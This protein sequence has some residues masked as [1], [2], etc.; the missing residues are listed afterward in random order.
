MVLAESNTKE[1]AAATNNKGNNNDNNK[2]LIF[3]LATEDC[4]NDKVGGG[5][6][7]SC[8][9]SQLP[10]TFEKIC[11]LTVKKRSWFPCQGSTSY[12]VCRVGRSSGGF[13]DD[14]HCI[15]LATIASIVRFLVHCIGSCS[16]CTN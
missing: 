9:S 7:V 15:F 1:A 6:C 8:F 12:E 14:L 3:S 5:V 4:G 11:F 16:F 13:Q 2:Y 10:P